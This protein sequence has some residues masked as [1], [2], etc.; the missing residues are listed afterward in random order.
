MA[1]PGIN[2]EVAAETD[3]T[4]ITIPQPLTIAA[5]NKRRTASGKLI[6]GVAAW[7]DIEGFKGRTH[8]H[9][10]ALAK[11]WDHRLTKESAGRQGNRLKEAAKFLGT[12]GLISLGGG[13]PSSEYFPFDELSVKVPTGRQFSAKDLHTSGTVITSG[14]HDLEEGKSLFDINTSFNY[15]QGTGAAQLLRFLVEHTELVH[16]PPYRD[17]QCTMTIGSTSALDMALRMFLNPGDYIITEEYT[18][19]AAV[20]TARQMGGRLLS[21]PIDEQGLLPDAID[22]ILTSWDP[23]VR[24]ARKPFLIYTVPSGQNPTGATMSTQRRRDLYAVAQKHD[25]FILED[26]PY[27]FLQMQPYTGPNA[28]DAPM[29]ATAEDFIK[30]LVPSLLSMDVDGRVMRMD[31]FSKVIAPGSRIGWITASAQLIERYIRH[32]DLSTQAPSGLSQLV[33]YKLLDEHW[34]HQGYLAWLLHI[35][36]EY[37]HRRDVMLGACDQYLPKDI[38]SWVAPAAGMFQWLKVD[39]TRHPS[40]GTKTVEEIE[41]AIFMTVIKKGALVMKGSYFYADDE[42]E[43]DTMYFRATYAAAPSDKIVEAVRRFGDAI[44]EEFGLVSNGHVTNGNGVAH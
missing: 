22:E 42:V 24:N 27:Y 34:G 37:T 9:H 30:S 36:A 8:H 4:A 39:W 43:H 2:I 15:G 23:A 20:E 12:P 40:Y 5:I 44:R 6:A 25:L 33:L 17:W 11:R 7:S 38:V 28:P 21:I 14:K 13:L 3:T 29:P 31:S 18:F 35:R 26:E 19:S 41:D 16:N 32:A 1:P 10:K